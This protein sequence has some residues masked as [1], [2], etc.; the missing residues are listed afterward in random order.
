MDPF[1]RPREDDLCRAIEYTVHHN[2]ATVR[3]DAEGGGPTEVTFRRPGGEHAVTVASGQVAQVAWQEL[4]QRH[5]RGQ[6]IRVN[7]EALATPITLDG[8]IE[9]RRN[10]LGEQHTLLRWSLADDHFNQLLYTER[11][12][13]GWAFAD[14][15][16]GEDRQ[17][18]GLPLEV[19]R[20]GDLDGV[21]WLE[22]SVA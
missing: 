13:F 19:R 14:L 18:F 21:S 7:R 4:N 16:P 22:W 17:I 1:G 5:A 9:V 11:Q 3:V 12:T 15:R 10:H 6:R 2:R 20:P 8:L